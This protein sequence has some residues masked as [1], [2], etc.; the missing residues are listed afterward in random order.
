MSPI[1]AKKAYSFA[2]EIIKTYKFLVNEKKE[3]VLAKQLPRLG[4]SI[5]ANISETISGQSKGDF[6]HRLNIA[7]KEARETSYWIKLLKDSEYISQKVFERISEK[8]SELIKI[9]C[10]IILI[11]KQKYFPQNNA[12][13]HNS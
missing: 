13:T 1:V 9:L 6:V 5:G 4:T 12:S 7:L 8:C 2:L 3:Y 11:T 10:S